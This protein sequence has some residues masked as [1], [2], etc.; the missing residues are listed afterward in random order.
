MVL[1]RPLNLSQRQ[2]YLSLDW[3]A[4]TDVLILTSITIATSAT[5]ATSATTE[6]GLSQAYGGGTRDREAE[7]TKQTGRG[8]PRL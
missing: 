7:E 5:S 3:V 1:T 4:S 2:M 6:E 8:L